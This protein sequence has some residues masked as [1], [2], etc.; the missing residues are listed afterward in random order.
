[1]A[2]T[3]VDL[4]HLLEDIR[5]SYP[6]P[7][8]EAILSELIANSLDSGC[9][10][11]DIMVEPEQHRLT[12]IDNGESM[13]PKQFEQYHD[14]AA[15]TKVRG[16]GIGFAGVGA[17]L[18]LLICREVVT[19]ARRPRRCHA[20][21]WWLES[22]Y[23]APWEE[24]PSLGIVPGE[25]GTGVRLNFKGDAASV[26]L[27]A[28]DVKE[29]VQRYFYPMLDHEFAKVLCHIY[30]DGVTM[31]VNGERVTVPPIDAKAAQYFVVRRGRQRKPIGIGFLVRSVKRL[32][33]DRRGLA[34]STFGKVIKRGWEWLGVT[35]LN[36]GMLTG[37]VE[38]PELVKCLTTTKSD[39][40]RDPTSLQKY[41]KFRKGIQD[42]V[43]GVLEDLGERREVEPRPD[44]T[45]R[46]LQ[47]EIDGV[48][49]EILPDFP[50]LAPLFGRKRPGPGERGL[51]ADE[52][53]DI[54]AGTPGDRDTS[55]E[56]PPEGG[57]A[58]PE[59]GHDRAEIEPAGLS[60]DHASRREP[61]RRRPGLMIGFDTET[62][63]DHL[64][65][66]RGETLYINALHPAYRRVH[67]TGLANLYVTFA[68][69]VTLSSHVE[70][71]RAPMDL[72]QRFMAAWGEMA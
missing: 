34:I 70:A 55:P 46:R 22:D 42:A 8:E 51:A 37:V 28:D 12:F 5:D 26:L 44:R 67:G 50:E 17:K 57:P 33:E 63:G 1:M 9:S 21:R 60:G 19:E 69:A 49:A 6:C 16:R 23:R 45:I 56:A 48:V 41:Y 11:I 43:I 14:I 72:M 47:R 30:P 38:V 53:A 7:M 36:P 62:G 71:G 59:S 52:E 18:A 64:A 13:T 10:R 4:R 15:T 65:W 66:L 39:F 29:I 58:E 25:K 61:R 2:E 20:S 40:M 27:S 24:T 3:R 35:P 31:T 54:V 32:P 68:V